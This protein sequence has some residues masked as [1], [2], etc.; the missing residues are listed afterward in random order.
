M[1][2]YLIIILTLGMLFLSVACNA[3]PSAE[4]ED[5]SYMPVNKAEVEKIKKLEEYWYVDKPLKKENQQLEMKNDPL[6]SSF[7]QFLG[8]I[9]QILFYIVIAAAIGAILF[10]LYKNADFFNKAISSEKEVISLEVESEEELQSLPYPSLIEKAKSEGD[11]R[12]AVRWYYLYVL[13]ELSLKDRISFSKFRTNNEYKQQITDLIGPEHALTLQF[14]EIVKAYEYTWFG[15]FD[16]SEAQ[17]TGIE[18]RY[19]EAFVLI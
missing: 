15:A 11:F 5:S 16:I 17:F 1:P 2:R 14:K 12:L 13:K 4:G 18:N 7:F 6:D 3:Q 8:G 19:K 10:F 9:F